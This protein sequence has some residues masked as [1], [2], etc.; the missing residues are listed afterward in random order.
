MCIA[1]TR[2]TPQLVTHGRSDNETT[3]QSWLRRRDLP[4][5]K[6]NQTHIQPKETTPKNPRLIAI[7]NFNRDYSLIALIVALTRLI[8]SPTKNVPIHLPSN[9]SV[10][11]EEL[12]RKRLGNEIG[13]E[14]RMEHTTRQVD[15]RFRVGAWGQRGA[16]RWTRLIRDPKGM[17][18]FVPQ[19]RRCSMPKRT[20]CYPETWLNWGTEESDQVWWPSRM[21]FCGLLDF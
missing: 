20:V 9:Q 15:S 18:K 21:F 6:I 14:P 17:R 5:F 1:H 11:E 8:C 12:R 7:K 4:T 3:Q 10:G 19:L 2:E 13:L 16:E